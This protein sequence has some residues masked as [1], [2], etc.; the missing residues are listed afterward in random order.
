MNVS[1][2]NTTGFFNKYNSYSNEIIKY[3]G[4]IK[5]I[6]VNSSGGS[7]RYYYYIFG[8]DRTLTFVDYTYLKNELPNYLHISNFLKKLN[9]NIPQI[10]FNDDKIVL[11]EYLGKKTLFNELN[12]SDNFYNYFK[13]TLKLLVELQLKSYDVI[14]NDNIL[15]NK[16]F[17]VEE[18]ISDW[19]YFK[20]LYLIYYKNEANEYI[21]KLEK[22]YYDASKQIVNVSYSFMHRD[23][24]SQNLHIY[25]D[26]IYL[27]DFQT[28]FYG[29]ILYDVVSLIEDPYTNLQVSQ[30]SYFITDY[31]N[32]IKDTLLWNESFEYFIKM[33]NLTAIFRLSQATAAYIKL[34]I[35][36]N[37][38]HFLKFLKYS[39]N[40]LEKLL[41]KS[42]GL[43][44]SAFI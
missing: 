16:I 4:A 35:I 2:I 43:S 23:F 26:D 19:N 10:F 27:I 33:Y 7:D 13:K 24:Q 32:F 30:K 5:K 20:E 41:H 14:K 29:P 34:G 9:I 38:S 31:Y 28:A 3:S 11:L 21:E 44:Q 22:F 25:N 15:N 17:G 39:V 18:F 1:E 37:K 40:N 8:T 12:N 42:K 6:Q 36:K